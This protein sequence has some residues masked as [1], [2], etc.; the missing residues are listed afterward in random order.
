MV[1]YDI[2]WYGM[3]YGVVGLY[4]MLLYVR[5]YDIVRFSICY[6]VLGIQGSK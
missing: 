3:C 6:G 1:L 5:L 4:C 2:V